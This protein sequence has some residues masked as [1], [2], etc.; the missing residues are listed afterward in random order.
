[1]KPGFLLGVWN[2]RLLGF[3]GLWGGQGLGNQGPQPS[4]MGRPT[5][6]DTELGFLLQK[7]LIDRNG[8]EK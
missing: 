3:E 2:L 5:R 8:A 4:S 1:M 6:A 7:N